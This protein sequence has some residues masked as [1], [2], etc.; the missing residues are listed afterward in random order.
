MQREILFSI[1][2][3]L[4]KLAAASSSQALVLEASAFRSLKRLVLASVI[5]LALMQTSSYHSLEML[6]PLIPTVWFLAVLSF[7]SHQT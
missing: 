1:E 7:Q 5:Q 2:Q 4:R 3:L 6:V